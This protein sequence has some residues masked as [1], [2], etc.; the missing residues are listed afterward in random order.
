MQDGFDRGQMSGRAQQMR[1]R[2][3]KKRDVGHAGTMKE[4]QAVAADSLSD[5][6]NG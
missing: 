4:L 6:G 5:A 1:D 2:L 3:K